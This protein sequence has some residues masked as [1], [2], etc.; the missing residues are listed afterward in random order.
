MGL[1][2][3]HSLP[4]WTPLTD[5]WAHGFHTLKR[6]CC[7]SPPTIFDTPQPFLSISQMSQTDREGPKEEVIDTEGSRSLPDS[8]TGSARAIR[9]GF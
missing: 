6:Y 3:T 9:S 1:V 8:T 2:Y 4:K 5:S 7:G